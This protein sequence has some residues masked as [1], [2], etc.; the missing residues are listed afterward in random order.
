MA[1]LDG[2]D[3]AVQDYRGGGLSLRI[4]T[5]NTISGES[6]CRIQIMDAALAIYACLRFV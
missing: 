4:G 5:I 2:L 3:W 1:R 6:D